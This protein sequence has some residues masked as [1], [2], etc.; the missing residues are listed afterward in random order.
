VDYVAFD[1]ALYPDIQTMLRLVRRSELE[2]G[3][4]APPA[5]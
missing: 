1:R 5:Q 2:S 4:R 3:W